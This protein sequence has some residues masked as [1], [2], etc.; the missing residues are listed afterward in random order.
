MEFLI[1]HVNDWL[2][3][4]NLFDERLSQAEAD[5]YSRVSCIS[6]SF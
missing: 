4:G 6:E 5:S 1:K 2:K 3:V